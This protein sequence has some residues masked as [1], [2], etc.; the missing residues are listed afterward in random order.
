MSSSAARTT[1]GLALVAAAAVLAACSQAPAATDAGVPAPAAPE[2]PTAPQADPEPTSVITAAASDESEGDQR[3][4]TRFRTVTVDTD[5]LPDDAGAEDLELPLFEDTTVV[6][7]LTAPVLRPE[8]GYRTWSGTIEGDEA[9]SVVLVERDGALSGYVDGAAGR[10]RLSPQPDGTTR[11]EQIDPTVFP[12]EHPHPVAPAAAEVAPAATPVPTPAESTPV[13]AEGAPADGPTEVGAEVGAEV[14]AADPGAPVIDVLIAYTAAAKTRM[15]GQAAMDADVALMVEQTN[16]AFTNSGINAVLRLVHSAEVDGRGLGDGADHIGLLRTTT[17]G[18]YDELHVLREQ[19][20]A[21]LIALVDDL[22]TAPYCGVAYLPG[23]IGTQFAQYGVSVND[24]RCAAGYLTFAH[25]V[26]HNFGAAHDRGAW[27]GTPVLPY[28]YDWVNPTQRWKTVMSYSNACSGC[29]T[30]LRFSNPDQSYNGAPVGAP[31]G[32]SNAADNRA[33]INTTASTISGY[34]GAPAPASLTLTAP[35]AAQR[36]VASAKLTATWSTSGFMGSDAKVELLQGGTVVKLLNAR[37]ALGSGRYE[38][39]VPLA[40]ARAENYRLRV[41]PLLAPQYA[42]T[43]GDFAVVDPQITASAPATTTAGATTRVSW[44]HTGAPGGTVKVELLKDGKVLSVLKTAAPLGTAGSGFAD[45]V[46]PVALNDGA[47][48]RFRTTLSAVPKAPAL[49]ADVS[50]TSSRRLVVTAP[51][52]GVTVTAGAPLAVTWTASGEVGTAVK[53]ELVKG[54]LVVLTTATAPVAAGTLTFTPPAKL[55]TGDDYRIR[56]VSAS[57]A[58]VVAA[59]PDR[60]SVDGTSLTLTSQASAS[61]ITAGRRLTITFDKVGVPGTAVKLEAL[62]P[63]LTPVVVASSVPLAAGTY[64]WAVPLNLPRA[65]W[66]IRATVVG[67][68][69]V[70]DTSAAA[71]T[72][73][74]PTLSASVAGTGVAGAPVTLSW[75][76]TD[77]AVAP[78][79]VRLLQDARVVATVTSN[80]VTAADGTGSL[81]YALPIGLVPGTYRFDVTAVANAALTSATGT[82]PVTRPGLTASA[83]GS[84]VSGAP[85]TVSWAFTGNAAPAVRVRLLQGTRLVAT[86]TASGATGADGTGSVSYRLPV[87]LEPGSY[88]FDVTPTAALTMLQYSGAVTVTRPTLSVGGATS[89]VRGQTATVSWAFTGGAAVPVKIELVQGTRVVLIRSGAVTAADGT[90]SYVYRAPTTLAVGSYTV[91]VRPV[92]LA[93]STAIEATG[94][95]TVS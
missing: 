41:T 30:L 60:F 13:G 84:G 57:F 94:S 24:A 15:G 27:S 35:T 71:T 54:D 90:G 89:V 53:A 93:A 72:V 43:S 21:D 50:V 25:E 76:F 80:G 36:V 64:S 32:A 83:S 55:P 9:S 14:V 3:D 95:F 85:V 10:F 12:G 44:T 38:Y 68:T 52:A 74:W 73:T 66:T 22:P 69:L 79:R 1:R 87:T 61:A 91:R 29:T 78:V 58:T 8:A 5:V 88:R 19:H 45:V 65:E 49:T 92:L 42:Q 31:A 23:G 48:Y 67:N 16:T 20:G 34:R 11:V 6:V 77:G 86:V 75:A 18:Y 56:L 62:A 40:T 82:L 51:G 17:D 37:V 47:G 33:L 63:G 81:A 59:S 4:V 28:G 39:V 7:D 2:V 46:L 26:G 70:T